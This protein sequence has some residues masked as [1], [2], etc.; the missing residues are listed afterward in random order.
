MAYW[1][2]VSRNVSWQDQ[3]DGALGRG[4]F[5]GRFFGIILW[6]C[7]GVCEKQPIR[8]TMSKRVTHSWDSN[9]LKATVECFSSVLCVCVFFCYLNKIANQILRRSI[10]VIIIV[11]RVTT[12]LSKTRT[13]IA[14]ISDRHPIIL[15]I[16]E[17]V[18]VYL[19][20]AKFI[21]YV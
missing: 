1:K 18:Y 11:E 7:Q 4:G 16:I 10:I 12:I 20:T 15:W 13:N 8:R 9:V 5:G 6:A 19:F 2:I 21:L 14:F 17:R 3:F